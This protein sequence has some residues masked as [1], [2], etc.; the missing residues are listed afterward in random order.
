MMVLICPT[1]QEENVRQSGTT[2]SL[3]M[4][5]M[6]GHLRRI[7]RV[8]K[9]Q[10]CPPFRLRTRIDGGHAIALLTLR[11][12]RCYDAF[13]NSGRAAPSADIN[14]ARSVFGQSSNRPSNPDAAITTALIVKPVK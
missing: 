4:T 7:R 14:L 13:A 2:G 5:C 1:A 9:A 8:G 11:L 6:R 3:R 10:A 12:L